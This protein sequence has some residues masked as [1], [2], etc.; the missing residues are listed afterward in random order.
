[1]VERAF[2]DDIVGYPEIE[3]LVATVLMC[4]RFWRASVTAP[5]W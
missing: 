2:G 4:H 5:T 1:M 3:T